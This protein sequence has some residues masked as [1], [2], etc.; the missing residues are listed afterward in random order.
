[1]SMHRQRASFAQSLRSRMLV[2]GSLLAL[3]ISGLAVGTGGGAQAQTDR[4][5]LIVAVP[6]DIQNLD[7]T[8]SSADVYTQEM[9]TNVYEWLVDYGLQGC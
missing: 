9:L 3:M 5:T 7:P 6:S 2:L 4:S 8:L 1:M